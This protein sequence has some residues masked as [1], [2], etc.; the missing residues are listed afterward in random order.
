MSHCA[1]YRPVL[2]AIGAKLK[3]PRSSPCNTGPVEEVFCVIPVLCHKGI[4]ASHRSAAETELEA[5]CHVVNR[6]D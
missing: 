2:Q 3:R 4:S 6:P 1:I 5:D